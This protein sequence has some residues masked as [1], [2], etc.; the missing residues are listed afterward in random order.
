MN[1]NNNII[2]YI[3]N[4]IDGSIKY[5]LD[6]CES[7]ILNYKYNDIA[8]CEIYIPLLDK[9]VLNGI[10]IGDFIIRE[11]TNT[12]MWIVSN[13]EFDYSSEKGI[14][15][16]IKGKQCISLL[17]QRIYRGQLNTSGNYEDIIYNLFEYINST[18][19]Y[20][21][22]PFN[23]VLT[24][25]TQLEISD[26]LNF[27]FEFETIYNIIMTICSA[28]NI[29]FEARY[30]R[31]INSI[32]CFSESGNVTNSNIVLS[33]NN[34][35][36][37]S[38]KKTINN[39]EFCNFVFAL[40]EGSGTSRRY[41][42]DSGSGVL[43]NPNKNDIYIAAFEAE[44]ISS[45]GNVITSEEYNNLLKNQATA[46]LN[47]HKL[48]NDLELEVDMSLYKFNTNYFIGSGVFV[49]L[50]TGERV[51]TK[52]IE[53]SEKWDNSGYACDPVLQVINN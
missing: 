40:G 41:S 53:V 26:G 43:T 12:D 34:N 16:I 5:I 19:G 52:V 10:K 37:V 36:L 44:N 29:H 31:R 27:Q 7:V 4:N 11:T 14:H 20:T 1:S 49:D 2:I 9:S 32:D 47:E 6:Y 8:D 17:Q 39:E 15:L 13:I 46:Y 45:N 23:Q 3:L 38:V 48:K 35:S 22:D 33:Q 42:Y 28:K 30:N 24:H 18:S 21:I 51:L 50:P 25:Y